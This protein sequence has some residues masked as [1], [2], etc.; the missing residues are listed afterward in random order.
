MGD[1]VTD[2]GIPVGYDVLLED[3]F[4]NPLEATDV[5]LSVD[6][7]DLNEI[8]GQ[9]VTTLP[10]V[11]DITATLD[12]EALTEP[13][14]DLESLVVRAGEP[15]SLDLWLEDLELELGETTIA[16]VDIFDQYGNPVDTDWILWADPAQG[17]GI[18][19][20]VLT[21]QEEGYYDIFASLPDGSLQDF[22]GPILIDSSGPDLVVDEQGRGH[23]STASGETYSG[24]AVD[25]YSG[26]AGVTVNGSPASLDEDGNWEA[27]VAY[28]FGLNVVET[29]AMDGD[30]NPTTDIRSTLSGNFTPNGDSIDN[31]LMVRINQDGFDAVED[32]ASGFLD[33][34]TIASQLP[35]PVLSESSK[36]CTWVLRLRHLVL[37][38]VLCGQPQCE[39]H[40]IESRPH[41]GRLHR[42]DRRHQ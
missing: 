32:M 35:S 21:F 13:L 24:T 36:S 19:Y 3:R 37:H 40:G 4:G 33:V 16:H 34:N 11:Y 23:M 14:V 27:Y 18:N 5:V 29:I 7:V 39:R 28:Q 6:P 12:S 38:Q 22:E 25:E 9:F 2:V 31:G 8:E 42:H 20:N 30:N 26:V 1:V 10:G 41:R 15:A 17:V